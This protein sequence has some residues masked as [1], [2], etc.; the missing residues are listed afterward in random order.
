MVSAVR[1]CFGVVLVI[2]VGF[3]Q[4]P[5]ALKVARIFS[6]GMVLQRDAAC[7]VWGWAAP[8][9]AVEVRLG[10]GSAKATADKDGRWR[11]ELPVGKA[12]AEAGMLTVTSA[13]EKLEI[14][15][16]LVGEVWICSGQ[17]N[18]EWP[19]ARSANGAE[20]AKSASAPAIRLFMVNHN[21]SAEPIADCAGSWEPA[22]ADTVSKWS[23]VGW[24]FGK[25]LHQAIGVPVGLIQTAW[26][27]TPAEAWTRRGAIDAHPDA[28]PILARAADPKTA[29]QNRACHLWNGMVAPLVPYRVRGVI[30]YQGESNI[31]QAWQYRTLFAAMIGDWRREFGQAEMPFGFVQLAPFSYGKGIEVLCAELRE[32]QAHVAKTVPGTG[33]AVTMDVGNPK[34]IHP[35]NKR[36]VGERLA[37]WARA[38]VYGRDVVWRGPFMTKCTIEGDHVTIEFEG[39]EGL[40][41]RDGKPP[42]CFKVAGANREFVDAEA[43]IRGATVVVRAPDVAAPS[44][45]R[46]A[47]WDAAEPNL[48]NGAGLPACPFRSDDWPARTK[49]NR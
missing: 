18:M 32:S 19:L 22:S 42:S 34:D 26:G 47:F 44:A 29:A 1:F 10:A 35:A 4:S 2:N 48:V 38:K 28:E 30:W 25:D 27:G 11:C 46:F 16:V 8:G 45:V 15:D 43:E 5:G 7:P 31:G 9:A 20:E 23:A 49:D 41:T 3:G 37:R 21:A 36:D 6:D 14:K 39:A 12:S 13:A 17:S 24:Y 40:K 33:M